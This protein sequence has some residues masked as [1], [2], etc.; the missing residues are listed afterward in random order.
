MQNGLEQKQEA[1]LSADTDSAHHVKFQQAA[2][3]AQPR[4]RGAEKSHGC[5]SSR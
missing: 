2:Q 4:F 1:Q 5:R 3:Q